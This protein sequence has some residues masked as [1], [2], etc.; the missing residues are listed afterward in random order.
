[1]RTEAPP[2]KT[3]ARLQGG[4]QRFLHQFLRLVLLAHAQQRVTVEGAAVLIQPAF[5][6]TGVSSHRCHS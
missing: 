2:E 6:G 4:Q 5:G 3:R 1:V